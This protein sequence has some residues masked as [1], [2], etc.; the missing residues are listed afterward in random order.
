[1]P[2][3]NTKVLLPLGGSGACA[4]GVACDEVGLSPT[5]GAAPDPKATGGGGATMTLSAG[6]KAYRPDTH[7]IFGKESEVRRCRLTFG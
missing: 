3:Y 2:E 7:D 6:G 4:S 1:M 5:L